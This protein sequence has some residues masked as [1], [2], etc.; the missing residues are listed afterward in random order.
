MKV[1]QLKEGRIYPLEDGTFVISQNETWVVG[2]YATQE[3]AELA[4][5]NVCTDEYRFLGKLRDEININQDR[6]I[7]VDDL[8]AAL[9]GV[10]DE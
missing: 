1:I 3:A 9:K 10:V 5:K 8:K 2:V 6:S 7:T 4:L